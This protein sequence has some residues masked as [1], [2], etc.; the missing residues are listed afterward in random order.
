MT[1]EGILIWNASKLILDGKQNNRMMDNSVKRDGRFENTTA[2]FISNVHGLV[3]GNFRVIVP[4]FDYSVA[5]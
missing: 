4:V 1:K 3:I 2:I 5:T